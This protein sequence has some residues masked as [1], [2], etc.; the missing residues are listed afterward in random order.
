[1]VVGSL[2]KGKKLSKHVVLYVLRRSGMWDMAQQIN[3]EE[4]NLIKLK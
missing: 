4:K 3:Q 2:Q 1:M